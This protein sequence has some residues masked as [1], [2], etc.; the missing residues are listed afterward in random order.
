MRTGKVK[1]SILR[2]SVLKKIKYKSAEVLSGPSAGKDATRVRLDDKRCIVF[3]TNPVTGHIDNVGERAFYRMAND[4]V[5]SGAVPAGMLINI[6]LPEGS[7]ERELKNIMDQIGT[8]AREYKVDILGGHTEVSPVVSASLLSVVGTGYVDAGAPIDS[9]RLVPGMELVMT[10]WAGASGAA[11]LACEEKDALETRFSHT[12]LEE[13]ATFSRQRGCIQDAA[14]AKELGAVA[15]HNASADGV[16]GALW[17]FA[18]SSGV[19]L[20]V[21]LKKIPIRQETVEICEFFDLNPYMI[22]SEGVLLAGT[23]DGNKL[24]AEYEKA[25][26]V[27]AVVG[28]VSDD[29]DRVVKNGD[30]TRFLVPPG[31]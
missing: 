19:G 14:I 7:E 26:I 12:F 1:E 22:S 21:D 20:T 29:N 23:T 3:S 24:V 2:R 27:A 10:K 16:F 4:I 15:M 30:E 28:T 5:V 13:A 11:E 6:V 25:G 8:L 17:E 31:R 9:S 18:E